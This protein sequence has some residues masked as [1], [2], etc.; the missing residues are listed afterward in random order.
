MQKKILLS[1]YAISPHRGSEYGA[2]WNAVVQLAKQHQLWVLYG[3]SDDH[4]GDTQTLRAY[5]EKS[6]VP[7]VTFVEVRAG[8]LA[9]SI[10]RLNKIGLGW[11][12]YFA[13]YLWQRQALKVARRLMQTVNFDVV[14]QFGPIG[15]R[16]PGFLGRLNKPLVWGPIGGMMRVDSRLLEGLTL[17][18]KLKFIAKNVINFVQLNFSLRIRRAFQ[19]ADVL[20]AASSDGQRTIARKFRRN[21]YLFSEQGVTGEAGIL[22]EKFKDIDTQVQLVW[23]GSHDDRKNLGL[24]LDALARV[25]QTNWVLNILGTG[26][27]TQSFKEKA[28]ELGLSDALRW[29]GQI[30]RNKAIEIISKSHLHI[31]TSVAED[32]P[33][34]VFEALSNGVPTLTIDHFG[35]GDVICNRCGIKIMVDDRESMASNFTFVLNH[36]LLHPR[37]LVD[38]AHTT[39]QCAAK[40]EWPARLEKLDG[41][42]D[43]AIATYARRQPQP[44]YRQPLNVLQHA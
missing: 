11:F 4:M 14:H 32:N 34:V 44:N 6:P 19:R 23:A 41:I 3:M 15:F 13:Y 33:A 17:K 43:E 10:N 30:A 24:C 12:F 16:E 26:P 20:M 35:M 39:L 28:R 40:H 25:K 21:S 27:L 8:W 5:L 37:I 29:H 22:A 7:S 2:A 9:M 18:G 42:Y 1:A 36:L 31:I 38:M